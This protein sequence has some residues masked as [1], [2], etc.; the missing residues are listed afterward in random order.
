VFRKLQGR[1]RKSCWPLAIFCRRS[2]DGGIYV[3]AFRACREALEAWGLNCVP[4]Q[5]HLD[6]FSGSKTAC[7]ARWP[8]IKVRRGIEHL[9]RNLRS[10]HSAGQSRAR[11]QQDAAEP[12]AKARAA[13][14]VA[15]ARAAQSAAKARA[16]RV[17]EAPPKPHLKSGRSIYAVLNVVAEIMFAPT[18]SYV[19]IALEAFVKTMREVWMEAEFADYFVQT[20]CVRSA[21]DAGKYGAAWLYTPEWWCGTFSGEPGFPSSQQTIEEMNSIGVISADVFSSVFKDRIV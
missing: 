6:W 11:N 17:R 5:M 15:K 8:H 14:P 3:K 10:N 13:Q 2:E 20:Y 19:H 16:A 1:W 4:K 18:R 21:V 7:L 9:R 12:A